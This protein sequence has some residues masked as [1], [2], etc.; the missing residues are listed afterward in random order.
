MRCVLLSS[1]FVCAFMSAILC[2]APVRA[3]LI[4]PLDALIVNESFEEVISLGMALG[5]SVVF[6]GLASGGYI[7]YSYSWYVD[8]VAVGNSYLLDYT[9]AEVGEHVLTLQV[10]DLMGQLATDS[11]FIHVYGSETPILPSTWGMLKA[12][13]R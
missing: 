13:F 6:I 5:G 3:D 10:N 12:M 11:A 9:A 8:S 4:P 2:A 1:L 7:P